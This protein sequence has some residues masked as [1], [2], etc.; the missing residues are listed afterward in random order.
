MKYHANIGLSAAV[1]LFLL[2]GNCCLLASDTGPAGLPA[3]SGGKTNLSNVATV[4]DSPLELAAS[5][6]EMANLDD[7]HRLAVGDTLS[8]RIVE[9]LDDPQSLVVADSGDL[10]VPYLGRVPARSKTCRQLAFEIK[11]ALEKTYYYHATVILAL[12]KMVLSLGR[13]YLA[14][15]F[16]TPGPQDIPSD[17]VLTLS[18]AILRAGG[19]S[20][21]ADGHKV[22]VI[23]KVGPDGNDTKTYTVDVQK[24]FDEGK[25]NLDMPLEPGD[26]IVVP[27]RLVRF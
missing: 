3:A 16:R 5:T 17:E 1:C 9:D 22:T 6:N 27:E 12:D 26:L 8:F 18:K 13:V 19:F 20:E 14:G 2:A 23:R 10:A 15:P 11:A 7:K 21:V 4:V 24:I 25:V